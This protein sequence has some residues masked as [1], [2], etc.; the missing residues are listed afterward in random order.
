LPFL[1]SLC[2]GGKYLTSPPVD[3]EVT[4]DV[5]LGQSTKLR[6]EVNT[7][8]RKRLICL[9]LLVLA[10]CLLFLS[11]PTRMAAASANE[12]RAT[13]DCVTLSDG[14]TIELVGVSEYPTRPDSWWRADGTPLPKPP[15]PGVFPFETPVEN[16]LM[17]LFLFTFLTNGQAEVDGPNGP[18]DE[19][20]RQ[21]ISVGASG[22]TSGASLSQRNLVAAIRRAARINLAIDY[23]SGP[24]RTVATTD[25]HAGKFAGRDGRPQIFWDN[26]LTDK[27]VPEIWVAHNLDLDAE[28][29]W[30][31]AVDNDNVVHQ[32]RGNSELECGHVLI[33]TAC[34]P[35][36]RLKP[37]S[38]YRL[39]THGSDRRFR[40]KPDAILPEPA[41]TDDI[42]WG[43]AAEEDGAATI[44]AACRIH[45]KKGRI[46]AID[47]RGGE[48]ISKFGQCRV[49][50]NL[51]LTTA[52]FP[53][54]P[55]A[56]VKE[57]RFQA[58][59]IHH[60]IEFRNVSLHAGQKNPAQIYLDGKRYVPKVK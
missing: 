10:A 8:A 11:R 58:R 33:R 7:I 56:R 49:T 26:P 35:D 24:W 57:F 2:L 45:M 3:C 36:L 54:L 37:V 44:S 38:E 47:E 23:E 53:R 40:F 50:G 5:C 60:H 25:G 28:H 12:T 59:T 22:A 31:V 43:S 1:V 42:V 20:D 18:K 52:V 13:A 27:L 32:S 19:C 51:C 14:A 15:M 9:R 16:R 55:L 41:P 21:D 6:N 17:R 34:F 30:L 39:W 48:C 4:A 46:L 29:L